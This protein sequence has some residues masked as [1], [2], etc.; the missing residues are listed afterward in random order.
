M[1]LSLLNTKQETTYRLLNCSSLK[2]IDGTSLANTA[3]IHQEGFKSSDREDKGCQGK[4]KRYFKV[5]D[6]LNPTL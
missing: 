1:A 5:T 4:Q 6:I 2:D 3:S